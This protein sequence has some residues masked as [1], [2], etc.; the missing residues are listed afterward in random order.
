MSKVRG[1]VFLLDVKRRR[2]VLASLMVAMFLSAMEGTIVST[3]MPTIIGDLGGFSLFAWVFSLFLL[4]QVVTIPIYGKLADVFGR[5]RVFTFGIVIF[6]IG[7]LLCGLSRSMIVLIVSRAVQGI[8]AGAVQSI[9]TT[10]VGDIYTLEERARVQGYIS[11]VWAL[12]SV[13]GPALGGLIVQTVGWS[14]VF[15]INLPVGVLAMVGVGVFHHEIRTIKQH[16]IDWSGSLLIMIGTS[17]LILALVEG[18]VAWSWTSVPILV[19]LAVFI[20]FTALFLLR[21]RA[22][23]EPILPLG[24]LKRPIIMY[25]NLLSLI[26]GGVTYGISS[27]TPTFAQGV[28]GTSSIVAGLTISTLSLGWPIASS[29]SG[30]LIIRRGF[31]FTAVLGMVVIVAATV[32]YAAMVNPALSP[33]ALAGASTV[34]GFGLGFA[35]TSSL[36]AVQTAV[37]YSQRGVATGAN[38]FARTLGSSLF[39]AVLSSVMNG[40][41]LRQLKLASENPQ[42]AATLGRLGG[43]LN[44]TNTLL[45]ENARQRLS[46]GVLH[47][48]R[49]ALTSGVDHAFWWL[50]AIA[51][52]GLVFAWLMPKNITNPS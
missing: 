11:S 4:A 30:S 3:A 51:A 24:L 23:K 6:L 45:N 15:W 12:A 41:I 17:A 22:A 5:K 20:V 52:A 2:F 33:F 47:I 50:L 8:G 35:S 37:D 16:A 39:V 25:G 18:G 49:G 46:P 38:M 36:I 1:A 14:W 19:S 7:S 9:A 40:E 26:V 43:H 13:V 31:R 27:F 34:F 10:I 29:L 42:F 44:V 48:L 28:L 32:L 21:E